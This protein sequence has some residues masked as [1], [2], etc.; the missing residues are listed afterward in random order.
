MSDIFTFYDPTANIT[1][2]AKYLAVIIE[3]VEQ[4]IT[5]YNDV[6]VCS[7]FYHPSV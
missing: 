4:T 1:R 5:Q 7:F 2:G 3:Y 6:E